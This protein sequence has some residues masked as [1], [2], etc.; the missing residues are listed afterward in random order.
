[1]KKS[2]G[3]LLGKFMPPHRG[4][5][6]LC[7]TAAEMVEELT[8]LVCSISADDIPGDLRHQWMQAA[9]PGVNVLHLHKDL[10]QEPKDHPDFWPIWRKEINDIHPH[11]VDM[12]FGSEPYVFRLAEELGAEPA[13]IDPERE[14]FPVSG[15]AIR[16]NPAANW[17]DIAPPA[18]SFFQK[19]LSLLGPESTG[20]SRLARILGR[21]FRTLFMPEYGR[22]YDIHY[23]QGE[24]W[25]E[26]D[27]LMLAKTHS[28]MRSAMAPDAGPLLIDDTDAIQ[29]AIW[30]EFLLKAPSPALEDFAATEKLADCYFVLSPD[31]RWVD[32]GVRYAGDEKVRQWFFEAAVTRLKQLDCRYHII[33]GENWSARTSRAIE[34]AEEL[35]GECRARP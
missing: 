13:L 9:L 28:A 14:L 34:L 20:K 25:K 17:D 29:T 5:L 21:H 31:V 3:F 1:M 18:R 4:H 7:R 27:L 2:R 16:Q 12:V 35:F 30:A 15:T 32:D 26:E 10:P 6:F 8:V 19:R 11:A 22:T 24:G 23:K 33:D